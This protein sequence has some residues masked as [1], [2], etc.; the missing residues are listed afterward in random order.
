MILHERLIATVVG[1]RFQNRRPVPPEEPKLNSNRRS[2][3]EE[4]TDK[5]TGRNQ[6]KINDVMEYN[7]I[8]QMK[9]YAGQKHRHKSSALSWSLQKL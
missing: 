9:Y 5:Y 6:N 4:G 1:R 7:K 2:D 8:K 3:V